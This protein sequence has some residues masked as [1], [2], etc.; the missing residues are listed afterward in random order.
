[1]IYDFLI[2]ALLCCVIG[3]EDSSHPLSQSDA[4][5]ARDFWR[6]ILYVHF[7]VNAYLSSTGKPNVCW[8]P[9]F[10]SIV[11][12]HWLLEVF[13]LTH[14]GHCDLFGFGFTT[15]S[16]KAP[17]YILSTIYTLTSV[18]IFSILFSA[19]HFFSSHDLNVYFRVDTYR[20]K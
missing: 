10:S 8:S 11:G 7:L 6:V 15:L 2:S 5:L 18:Y 19:D 3:P 20:R 12:S 4:K 16:S 13:P 1:M 14:T 17:K 9:K